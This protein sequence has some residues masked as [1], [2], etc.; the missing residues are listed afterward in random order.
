MSAVLERLRQRQVLIVGAGPTGL[1]LANALAAYGVPFD[2]IDRKAG[3]SRDSKALAVN[4]LSRFQLALLG[5][6]PEIGSQ[7]HV[8]RKFR[9][10]A[11][12]QRLTSIDFGRVAFDYKEFVAQ[13]QAQ[14][15]LDLLACLASCHHPSWSTEL[16]D[17]VVRP[18]FVRATLRLA[19]GQTVQRE[20]EYIVG[21]DGK[22]SGVRE[23]LNIDFQGHEYPMHF[24]LGDYRVELPF[25]RDEAQYFVYD[26]T[27]F[28]AVPLAADEWRIVLKREGRYDPE[29]PPDP[30]EIPRRVD[31]LLRRRSTFSAP[32]WISKAPFYMKIASSLGGGRVFICGD[33]AHLFSPIGGTGMN[34][35]MQDALNLGWK[36]AF[37]LSDRALAGTLLPTYE[38]ERLPVI[39]QT[40][41]ATDLSTKLICGVSREPAD[42]Q[43]WLPIVRNRQLIKRTL[44]LQYSGLAVRYPQSVLTHAAGATSPV[45]VPCA[46]LVRVMSRLGGRTPP[47]C[48]F[49]VLAGASLAR[50]RAWQGTLEKVARECSAA[51][52]SAV[53][54][55]ALATDQAPG[56]AESGRA[57]GVRVVSAGDLGEYLPEGEFVLVVRPDGFVSL[58]SRLTTFGAV[59][60]FLSTVLTMDV[61][62]QASATVS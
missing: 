60:E 32:T 61:A 21:C 22:R 11:N 42:I 19:N 2:I 18:E 33:A 5:L 53:K 47:G 12:G 59:Q 29:V 52:G 10:S 38:A 44:P 54:V 50:I 8:L 62:L 3:I 39:E 20:Y 25:A 57:R 37:V 34:T 51:Y 49:H 13:P 43:P 56:E 6:S 27:F 46:G 1:T 28:I 36:L 16:A 35:G 48:S 31:E 58:A 41:R 26:S 9:V 4:V 55:A 7:G 14:T 40:A 45:G 30:L 15:E 17:L 24:V 23:H